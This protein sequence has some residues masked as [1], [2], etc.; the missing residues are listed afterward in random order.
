MYVLH[1]SNEQK[2]AVLNV[3]VHT[4][5]IAIGDLT[6]RDISIVCVLTRIYSLFLILHYRLII[7]I[8][9]TINCIQEHDYS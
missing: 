4:Y 3:I 6:I 7:F 1:Y 9:D 8:I 5:I 2:L